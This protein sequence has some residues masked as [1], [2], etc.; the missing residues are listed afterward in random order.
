MVGRLIALLNVGVSF[1]RS[2]RCG[3]Y[4]LARLSRTNLRINLRALALLAIGAAA[5]VGDDAEIVGHLRQRMRAS[6]AGLPNYTCLETM[7]RSIVDAA[8]RLL[9]RERLRMEVL[10][11]QKAEMFAWPG[12]SIFGPSPLEAWIGEGAIGSGN[13]GAILTNLFLGSTAAIAYAG[14]EHDGGRPALRFDFH[15]PLLSSGYTLSVN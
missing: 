6:V 12:S 10:I 4:L 8:G 7:E 9:F 3:R 11:G 5:G 1:R 14:P 2:W 13:F 15:A